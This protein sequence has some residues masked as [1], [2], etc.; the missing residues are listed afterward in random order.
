MREVDRGLQVS[1]S[2]GTGEYRSFVTGGTY[3]VPAPIRGCMRKRRVTNPPLDDE[4]MTFLLWAWNV[5]EINRKK[6]LSSRQAARLMKVH[7]TVEG[8]LM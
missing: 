3:V 8:Q 7:G 6:K 2:L 5:G 4:Q 1:V